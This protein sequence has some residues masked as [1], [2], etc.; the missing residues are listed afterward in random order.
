VAYQLK[1]RVLF[2]EYDP[3]S[4]VHQTFAGLVALFH[5][6]RQKAADELSIK[7]SALFMPLTENDY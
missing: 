5:H 6:P 4:F 7:L 1:H 2:L 3:P